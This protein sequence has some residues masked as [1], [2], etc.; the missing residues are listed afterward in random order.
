MPKCRY[1]RKQN[2]VCGVH[3]RMAYVLEPNNQLGQQ[4]YTRMKQAMDKT[5]AE[6]AR[7][8]AQGLNILHAQKYMTPSLGIPEQ[9][10]PSP[11]SKFLGL[12]GEGLKRLEEFQAVD[13]TGGRVAFSL[14]TR[15][16]HLG[17]PRVCTCA[18][19]S[20]GK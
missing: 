11:F 17:A 9:I 1:R 10:Q 4:A 19:C 5:K 18:Y 3:R 12:M 7:L 14:Y 2:G 15:H 6:S 8:E 16:N 20:M 13:G